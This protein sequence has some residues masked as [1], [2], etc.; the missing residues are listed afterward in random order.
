[1]NEAAYQQALVFL[2]QRFLSCAELETK[3]KRKGFQG[4]DIKPVIEKLCDLDYLN[5]TRLA[6]KVTEW[7]MSEGKYGASY[8]RLKMKQRGLEASDALHAYDEYKAASKQ[9]YKKKSCSMTREK[10]SAFL[11]RRGF[12][13]SVVRETVKSVIEGAEA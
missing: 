5:D 8:I 3:L 4:D 12:S 1:M 10:A 6:A 9:L 13:A 11:W 2:E 7:H